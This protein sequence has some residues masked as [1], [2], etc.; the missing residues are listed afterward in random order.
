MANPA[1]C[2][3]IAVEIVPV[4]N[5][6]TINPASINVAFSTSNALL[7]IVLP[8]TVKVPSSTLLLST[9]KVPSI[10]VLPSTFNPASKSTSSV[11]CNFPV[12]FNSNPKSAAPPIPTFP[13]V[14][15]PVAFLTQLS[16]K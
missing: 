16:L 5:P 15:I 7:R 12:T 9:F 11:T 6:V 10:C 1:V 4:V 8:P 2:E 13:V 14:L 3:K